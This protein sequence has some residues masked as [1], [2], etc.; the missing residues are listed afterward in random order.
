MTSWTV[1][2]SVRM[3]LLLWQRRFTKGS[4]YCFRVLV[5]ELVELATLRVDVKTD[6]GVT[7]IGLLAQSSCV[8]TSVIST[9]FCVCHEV[10]CPHSGSV[11]VLLRSVVSEGFANLS[12]SL[13]PFSFSL[14][15]RS[16]RN[17]PCASSSQCCSNSS[18]VKWTLKP[19]SA[20]LMICLVLSAEFFFFR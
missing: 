16:I 14:K 20:V 7:E 8:W 3:L 15:L 12:Q 4:H 18:E 13:V 9:S 2:V 6:V 17:G 19:S 1:I 5:R 11:R 10:K